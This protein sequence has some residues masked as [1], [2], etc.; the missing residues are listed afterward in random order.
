MQASDAAW[1]VIGQLLLNG[2]ANDR[3]FA[4]STL[5]LKI[6]RSWDTL[7]G[8]SHEPLR[9]SILDWISQSAS[10]AY[11]TSGTAVKGEKVVMRKLAGAVASLSLRL[12]GW[13]D[14]LLELVMRVS[15]GN[16]IA[17]SRE[18]V[19]EVLSVVVEQIGRAEMTGAAKYVEPND[20]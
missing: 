8:S 3:F 7:P 17:S 6:S 2:D 12:E 15:S 5:Q 16:G 11:P 10:G 13:N 9:T 19:L 20:S 14:W 18:A 4:A 1:S